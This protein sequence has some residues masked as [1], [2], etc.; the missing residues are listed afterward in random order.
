MTSKGY[1]SKM[2]RLDVAAVFFKKNNNFSTSVFM[3]KAH[4]LVS[5]AVKKEALEGSAINGWLWRE[6][7]ENSPWKSSFELAHLK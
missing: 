3:F 4:V 1:A 6:D 2:R 5:Q 7:G